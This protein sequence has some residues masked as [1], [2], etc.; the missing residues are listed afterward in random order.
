MH[1]LYIQNMMQRMIS[2]DFYILFS[3]KVKNNM[4]SMEYFTKVL[5]RI[6]WYPDRN[7]LK[8]MK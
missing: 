5:H 7:F 3:R 2:S 8:K 6:N 4:K 1:V